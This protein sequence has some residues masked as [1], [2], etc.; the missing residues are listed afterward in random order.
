[1]SGG[2]Q[3]GAQTYLHALLCQTDIVKKREDVAQ[4]S[5]PPQHRSTQLPDTF[6]CLAATR[7]G[8]KHTCPSLPNRHCQKERGGLP[9]TPLPPQ[10]RSTQL[11]DA[12]TSPRARK[13]TSPC[14]LQGKASA[15]AA[16][17]NN[18]SLISTRREGSWDSL[19]LGGLNHQEL[20]TQG[21]A[22]WRVATL[23]RLR[24][25]ARPPAMPYT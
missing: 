13:L 1:M 4:N 20:A 11:Q 18:S 16:E 2:G 6:T 12:F 22:P 7:G 3:R 21:R 17:V 24:Q 25:P 19:G 10:H 8:R 15:G 9:R 5:P 23:G 14:S